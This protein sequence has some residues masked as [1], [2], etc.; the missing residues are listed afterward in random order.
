[1]RESP[2]KDKLSQ[3]VKAPVLGEAETPE[4][5]NSRLELEKN[6]IYEQIGDL[7]MQQNNLMA[8]KCKRKSLIFHG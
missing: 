1:V 3:P 7:I 8:K 5:L 6:N 2:A 4:I